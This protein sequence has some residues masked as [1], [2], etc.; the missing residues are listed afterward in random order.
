[1]LTFQSCCKSVGS[2]SHNFRIVP[3]FQHVVVVCEQMYAIRFSTKVSNTTK[4]LFT[5]LIKEENYIIFL[6]ALLLSLFLLGVKSV[7]DFLR[8]IY[9]AS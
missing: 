6:P 5:N 1:M 7:A 2:L 8:I 4:D 9:L 3:S